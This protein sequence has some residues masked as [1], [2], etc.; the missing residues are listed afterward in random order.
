MMDEWNVCAC[1]WVF[2]RLCA[3][4]LVLV[5]NSRGNVHRQRVEGAIVLPVYAIRGI[6]NIS[7]SHEMY[8]GVSFAPALPEPL[9]FMRR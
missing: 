5:S 7:G 8:I 1:R 2:I 3:C 9:A 4:W 6:E